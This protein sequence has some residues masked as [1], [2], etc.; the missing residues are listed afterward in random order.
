MAA[1]AHRRLVRLLGRP[2]SLAAAGM[3][4]AS[5]LTAAP[6]MANPDVRTAQQQ[7]AAIR[8]QVEQLQTEAEIAT[9]RYNATESR[10]GDV[11]T[12]HL[13]AQRRLDAAKAAAADGASQLDRRMRALYMAGGSLSLVATVLDATDV[14]DALTRLRAVRSIVS[15]DRTSLNGATGEVAGAEALEAQLRALAKESTRL[16]VAAA[17][18]ADHVRELLSRRQAVLDAADQQ[19]ARLVAEQEAAARQAAASQFAARLAAARSALTV[20]PSLLGGDQAPNATA[21]AAIAAAQTRIGLPYVWGATG[22]GAFD[23]SG[24]TQWAYLQAGVTLPRVAADQ[25]NSG[26]H[27]DLAQLAPGDLLFWATDPSDPSTI[28]HVAIYLGGGQMIAAPHTGDVVKVQPVYLT[29]FMGAT[30]PTAG[31]K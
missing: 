24:L 29:E 2:V 19:V 27:P 9:E 25:W 21:A 18:T 22:P 11:V 13:L 6:A 7:A 4:A 14:N 1:V 15:A 17:R 31:R 23:C 12:Q 10:L 16:Q 26:P 28:H 20:D 3:L 8:D 30:R 5:T